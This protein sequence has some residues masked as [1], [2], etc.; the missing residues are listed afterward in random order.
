[1]G[2]EQEQR[3]QG[4]ACGQHLN[5]AHVVGDAQI[6]AAKPQERAHVRRPAETEVSMYMQLLLQ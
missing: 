6:L 4:A 3:D 5:Q 1:V 2:L